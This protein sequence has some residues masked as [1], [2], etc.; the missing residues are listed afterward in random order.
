MNGFPSACM[1]RRLA[2]HMAIWRRMQ[3]I[4]CRK[5]ALRINVTPVFSRAAW[6]CPV[7]C[8]CLR[9]RRKNPCRPLHPRPCR[10]KSPLSCRPKSPLSCRPKNPLLSRPKSPLSCRPKSPLS[11]RPKN[12]LLSRPKSLQLSRLKNPLSCRPK[13]PLLSRLRNPRRPPRLR[14]CRMTSK[15]STARM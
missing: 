5:R 4:L 2:L 14:T 3:C 10:R 8:W 11:S 13:S 9:L 15:T 12:L 1:T 7:P 6:K